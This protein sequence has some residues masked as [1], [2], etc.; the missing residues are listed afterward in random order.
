MSIPGYVIK[1]NNQ[2]GARHGLSERQR[3]HNKAKRHAPRSG[4]SENMEAHPSIL[5]RWHSDCRYRDS[6]TRIGWTEQDIMLF[7]RFAL[8]KH[9]YVATTAERIR[10][11]EHWIR[12][13]QSVARRRTVGSCLKSV[14]DVQE[15]R[16]AGTRSCASSRP[17]CWQRGG[18]RNQRR[19]GPLPVPKSA[20]GSVWTTTPP[21]AHAGRAFDVS[22]RKVGR[23]APGARAGAPPAARPNHRTVA[24]IW[25]ERP[26][27][28]V[29]DV[30]IDGAL[31]AYSN[32]CFCPGSSA[33]VHSFLLQ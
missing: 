7:D 10:H 24:S 1:K 28:L 11:P 33:S 29:E 21:F 27:H 9:S 16:G 14:T 30:E 13:L 6:V 20:R 2:R 12:N 31:V 22:R 4:S 32:N 19:N 26:L 8:G 15:S 3:I 17:A 18:Q 5:A 25:K 23:I